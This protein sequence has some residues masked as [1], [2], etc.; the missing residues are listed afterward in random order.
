VVQALCGLGLVG[1][2]PGLGE[3]GW[4]EVA[5]GGVGSVHV[6]VDASVLDDHAC[7][8]EAVELPAVEQLVA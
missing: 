6:V 5:V 1:R 8:E 3:L 7:F 4:G 2:G